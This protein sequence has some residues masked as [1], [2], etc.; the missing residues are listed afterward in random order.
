LGPALWEFLWCLDRITVE[1]GGVGKVRDGKPVKAEW[2]AADLEVNKETVKRNLKKLTR[3]KYLR[4]RRTAYGYIIEVMNSLKFG[5]W[6]PHKRSEKN[7]AS[8][9][10]E[11]TKVSL[12]EATRVS[13]LLL[14]S[15]TTQQNPSL[16]GNGFDVFWEEYPRKVS[17]AEA[18]KAWKKIKPAEVP[19]ILAGLRVWKQTEQ[20]NRDGGRFVPYPSTFLNKRR[21]DIEDEQ[22]EQAD[23]R[24][25]VK[26]EVPD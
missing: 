11:T 4:L 2:I 18:W 6:A 20:W 16:E 23:S 21:W 22:P 25:M 7:V 3:E 24:E 13:S 15:S 8:D 10:R 14:R 17:K 5:I 9:P 1:I 19:K 26:L 12:P